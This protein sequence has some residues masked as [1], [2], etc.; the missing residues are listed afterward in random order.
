MTPAVNS[1]EPRAVMPNNREM[2]TSPAMT[3]RNTKA[4]FQSI[5]TFIIRK[6]IHIH[7]GQ[8]MKFS[9]KSFD[10]NKRSPE[11]TAKLLSVWEASVRASH[12][13]LTETDITRLAPQAEEALRQI[14]IL[15][16]VED[17]LRPIGFMGVQER[18]IEMLFLHPD[19]FRKGLGKDVEFVDVNEQNPAARM[20]YERMG[21]KVFKRDETDSEGRPFP[22]LEMKR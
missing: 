4:F 9:I 22:I 7:L 14:E 16:I 13:F 5:S 1:K 12:H 10:K 18:K 17:G 19:Y 6:R 2:M 20:F 21:F 15:W 11:L 8:Y 3:N